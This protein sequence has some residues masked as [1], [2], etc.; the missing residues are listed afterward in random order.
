MTTDL[1]MLV[2]T[3]VFCMLSFVP[4]ASGLFATARGLEWGFSNRDTP[5]DQPAWALRA[6]RA[7]ANLVENLGPFAILV[8]VAHVSGKANASTALGATLFFWSRIAYAAAYIGGIIYVRTTL[9][10][11]ALIG[12]LIILRQLF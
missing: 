3:G 2:W 10:G 12:E 4:Y 7:H 5:L 6:R 9:F 11:V 1:W 8:L